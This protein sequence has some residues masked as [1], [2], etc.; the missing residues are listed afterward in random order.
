MRLGRKGTSRLARHVQ[1][2]EKSDPVRMWLNDDTALLLLP[3][4]TIPILLHLES[5]RGRLLGDRVYRL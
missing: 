2:K 4:I 3:L 5:R 1:T